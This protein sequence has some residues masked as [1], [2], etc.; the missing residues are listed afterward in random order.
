MRLNLGQ[1]TYIFFSVHGKIGLRPKKLRCH[2]LKWGPLHIYEVGRIA[3]HVR[4][5]KGRKKG[6]DFI[7][8]NNLMSKGP[9][10]TAKKSFK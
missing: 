6:E 7:V 10:A 4:N 3:E 2:R 5:G 1:C 8:L 9:W